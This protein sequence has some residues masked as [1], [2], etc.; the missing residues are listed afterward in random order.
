MIIGEQIY[1][2]K[3]NVTYTVYQ[4]L[5][6]GGQAEVAYVTSNKVKNVL[7]IKRLLNIRYSEVGALAEK[8]KN[9]EYNRRR[10]YQDI[11]KGTLPG[12]AC[13]YIYDF[14][15]ENTFYYVVTEKIDAVKF[16]IKQLFNVLPIE[17]KLFLFRI[18]A[19]SF[20]PLEKAGIIHA[21]VKPEN[22][23]LKNTGEQYV[24]KLI[25]FESAFHLDTPPE[26]GCIVGTEPYYSPELAEYNAEN[27]AVGASVLTTKSDIFSLGIILYEF[28]TGE[29]P[30]PQ[31]C[32]KYVFEFIKSGGCVKMHLDWSPP[33]CSLIKSMLNLNPKY[34]P[35]VIELLEELKKI[36]DISTPPDSIT[37]PLIT[38]R[39]ETDKVAYVSILS[40]NKNVDI[41]YNADNTGWIEY[42]TPFILKD[43]DVQLDI[44]VVL[45]KSDEKIEKKKFRYDISVSVNRKTKV[46]RPIIKIIDSQ[47]TIECGNSDAT[48]HYTLDGSSPTKK[49]PIYNGRFCVEENVMIKAFVRCVGFLPSDVVSINSSSKVRFS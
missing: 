35:N 7:F 4:T 29:Y 33:L 48:I 21:D 49:S 13:S 41:L 34:R 26:K 18:I 27:N 17:D 42:E 40:L 22:I 43:D 36:T 2:N 30:V 44:Q 24:A 28:L 15:R 31:G 9:F 10:V 47:V 16:D 45:H 5:K 32:G 3:T 14:F 38:I 39:R 23:L 12:G 1:S 25:D 19:Y 8:C 11:N 20:L 6:S 37:N 46:S